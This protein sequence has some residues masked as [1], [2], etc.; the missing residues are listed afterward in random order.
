M[1]G[2]GQI[3]GRRRNPAVEDA[4]KPTEGLARPVG[5]PDSAMRVTGRQ[6]RHPKAHTRNR[7]LSISSLRNKFLFWLGFTYESA[8]GSVRGEAASSNSE[9]AR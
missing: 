7:R 9:V 8:T 1:F 2:L 5:R 4:K 6:A 3:C